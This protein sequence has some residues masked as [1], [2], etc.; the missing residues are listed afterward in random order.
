MNVPGQNYDVFTAY[1]DTLVKPNVLS[2][3]TSITC[4][5]SML[6]RS[7]EAYKQ[8]QATQKTKEKQTGFLSRRETKESFDGQVYEGEPLYYPYGDDAWHF[9]KLFGIRLF[10]RVHYSGCDT[11]RPTMLTIVLPFAS[12]KTVERFHRLILDRAKE[13][14]SEP[15]ER[16][17]EDSSVPPH[18]AYIRCTV[19]S[20]GKVEIARQAKKGRFFSSVITEEGELEKLTAHLEKFS[21]KRHLYDLLG[22]PF[23]VVILLDGVPGTGKSTLPRALA[24]E[25]GL[26]LI[27]L[28][29]SG[30]SPI[31]FEAMTAKLPRHPALFLIEDIDA[32]GATTGDRV[33]GKESAATAITL[34]QLLNFL[35]GNNS[36]SGII[37][38]TSNHPEKFDKAMMRPGRIDYR[39]TLNGLSRERAK[40]LLTN[41]LSSTDVPVESALVSFEEEFR[42]QDLIIPAAVQNLAQRLVF[43]YVPPVVEAVTAPDDDDAE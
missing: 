23:K 41:F 18:I 15:E 22:V 38:I 12:L 10:F 39:L 43:G 34:A 19:D 42:D 4:V 20:S 25:Y 29:T 9:T 36:P 7:T 21:S 33:E 16:E 30:I 17:V 13:S 32:T 2:P 24:T 8:F 6:V 40:T 11:S 27:E 1:F 26:E 37:V 14:Q 35:D 31:H 5:N 3:T 28:I